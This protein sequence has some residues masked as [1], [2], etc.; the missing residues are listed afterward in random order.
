[1]GGAEGVVDVDVGQLGQRARPA[2]GRSRSRPARSG[3]S[4]APARRRGS[5]SRR[6]RD[7]LAHHRRGQRHVSVDQLG[8]PVGGRPQ[9][10]LGLAVLGP[11]EVGDEHQARAAVAAAPRS[12]AAQRGSACRRS[13][14]PSSS[15]TLKSTRTSTRLPSGPPGPRASSQQSLDEVRDA[16]G[17]A[18]LVVVPGDDLDHRPV[19]HRGQLR[20]DDRGGGVLDDV[21]GDDRVL[22][23]L[24]QSLQR[25]L[26]RRP[27]S[28]PR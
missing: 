7:L 1:M 2:Q 23:V 24:E 19:H 4:R 25:P 26:R 11:P 15:G 14:S 20:V 17:V 16:V 8:Q 13:R 10:E 12:S 3:R 27:P 6:T 5:G 18:P 22:G 21:R 9:R 28:A